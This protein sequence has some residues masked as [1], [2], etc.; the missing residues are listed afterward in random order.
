MAGAPEDAYVQPLYY[1]ASR[2][3]H[4]LLCGQ[5]W[6]GSADCYCLPLQGPTLDI[7]PH[8]NDMEQPSLALLR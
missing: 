2:D 8:D 5:P 3:S 4:T 7:C 6:C 1:V